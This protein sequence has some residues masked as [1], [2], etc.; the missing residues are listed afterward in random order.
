MA[1]AAGKQSFLVIASAL[2]GCSGLRQC[3]IAVKPLSV[4]NVDH[5][6]TANGRKSPSPTANQTKTS[7]QNVMLKYGRFCPGQ[8]RPCFVRGERRE[9]PFAYSE[10]CR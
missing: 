8:K 6:A 3:H 5:A 2:I 4:H 10:A 1:F 7:G 9:E